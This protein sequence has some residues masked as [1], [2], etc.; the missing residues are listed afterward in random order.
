MTLLYFFLTIK[1][2]NYK[3]NEKNKHIFYNGSKTLKC[4]YNIL[5]GM[6]G[7]TIGSSVAFLTVST[8]VLLA[9]TVSFFTT[10]VLIFVILCVMCFTG[11]ESTS[12]VKLNWKR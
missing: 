4:S 5:L 8:T 11:L 6:S 10:V 7:K 12:R 3:N 9:A 1:I 2:M